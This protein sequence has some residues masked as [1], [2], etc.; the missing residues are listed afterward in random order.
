MDFIILTPKGLAASSRRKRNHCRLPSCLTRRQACTLLEARLQSFRCAVLLGDPKRSTWGRFHGVVH[1][2]KTD[3]YRRQRPW[4]QRIE[5]Y[6]KRHMKA[7]KTV[8]VTEIITTGGLQA[9]NAHKFATAGLTL[10]DVSGTRTSVYI[11][12]FT[13]DFPNLQARDN[14]GPSIYRKLRRDTV[15]DVSNTSPPTLFFA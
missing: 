4:T 10:Q 1:V 8:S 11:G 7:L 6:L 5:C 13:G 15:V 3:S 12:T 14:E 9:T 2:A